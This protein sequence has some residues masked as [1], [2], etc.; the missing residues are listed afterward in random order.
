MQEDFMT[1]RKKETGFRHCYRAYDAGTRVR[2]VTQTALQFDSD[3]PVSNI[4]SELL[5]QP[6]RIR[7]SQ[8]SGFKINFGTLN[9]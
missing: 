7:S 8:V 3:E 4:V 6:L 5:L 1:F 9:C 2:H